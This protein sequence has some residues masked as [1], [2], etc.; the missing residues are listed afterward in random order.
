MRTSRTCGAGKQRGAERGGNRGRR[1]AAGAGRCC[2]PRR[3]AGPRV[4]A[5]GSVGER[6]VPSRCSCGAVTVRALPRCGNCDAS[7]WKGRRCRRNRGPAGWG[8]GQ[9]QAPELVEGGRGGERWHLARR[10]AARP[11]A[12]AAV[13]AV[14]AGGQALGRA[15]SAAGDRSRCGLGGVP[16]A[17]DRC[18]RTF[19]CLR[20]GELQT[21]S[22][23][24]R[25]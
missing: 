13:R 24:E 17:E 9:G 21:L 22:G 15:A 12:G 10:L 6:V 23:M 25:G 2:V 16:P 18:A 4:C 8:Q 11:S 14:A 20:S 19:C 5:R 1:L 7:P 3:L